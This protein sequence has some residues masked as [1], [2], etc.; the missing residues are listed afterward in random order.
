MTALTI[1]RQ[2]YIF[3]KIIIGGL[4]G[5]GGLRKQ[6]IKG[7]PVD[8]LFCTYYRFFMH[9]FQYF[10]HKMCVNMNF[11][12]VY[13]YTFA[14]VTSLVQYNLEELIW[15]SA[16]TATLGSVGPDLSLIRTLR[17]MVRPI[18]VSNITATRPIY[19][20]FPIRKEV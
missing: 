16:L 4:L 20:I 1:D 6:L 2:E 18:S 11:V 8:M 10:K 14:C 5:H 9:N 12:Y 17:K 3:E 13:T 7:C 15:S 19:T